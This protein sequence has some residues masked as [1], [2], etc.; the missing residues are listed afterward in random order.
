MGFVT[1][2]CS[3]IEAVL[4]SLLFNVEFHAIL[5]WLTA[6]RLAPLLTCMGL[7]ACLCFDVVRCFMGTWAQLWCRDT[8][9]CVRIDWRREDFPRT[10]RMS[11]FIKC[12]KQTSNF[13]DE[14]N[15]SQ[16]GFR[17]SVNVL[18]AISVSSLSGGVSVRVT[19]FFFSLFQDV[20]VSR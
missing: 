2:L 4:A 16:N 20:Q 19:L 13:N 10:T 11:H 8:T 3:R 6:V 9:K 18:F 17:T 15:P 12:E 5:C 7:H 14:I 1:V